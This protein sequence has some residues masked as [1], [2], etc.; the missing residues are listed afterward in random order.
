MLR[1]TTIEIPKIWCGFQA[2]LQ[3]KSSFVRLSF[4]ISTFLY[5][6]IMP[7]CHTKVSNIASIRCMVNYSAIKTSRFKIVSISRNIRFLFNKSFPFRIVMNNFWFV[8]FL[9]GWLVISFNKDSFTRTWFE[10]LWITKSNFIT[11]ISLLTK[12][13]SQSNLPFLIPLENSF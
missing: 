10:K 5:P 2:Y 8:H 3:N 1:T 13:T 9:F 7:I 4:I 11:G 12:D 6:Y